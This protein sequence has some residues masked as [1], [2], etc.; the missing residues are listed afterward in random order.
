MLRCRWFVNC[1]VK[2]DVEYFGGFMKLSKVFV[3]WILFTLVSIA[4]YA[5]FY[6]EKPSYY[7][8]LDVG[9][10]SLSSANVT[11]D[12]NDRN[13]SSKDGFF[14]INNQIITHHIPI[15]DGVYKQVNISC[16]RL[17]DMAEGKCN[18]KNFKILNLS[19]QPVFSLDNELQLNRGSSLIIPLNSVKLAHISIVSYI[20]QIIN[21]V[22]LLSLTFCFALVFF[23]RRS[24]SGLIFSCALCIIYAYAMFEYSN[25]YTGTDAIENINVAT[26][27]FGK[28]PY[29][30][31]VEYRGYLWFVILWFISRISAVFS[32][33]FYYTYTIYGCILFALTVVVLLPKIITVISKKPSRSLNQIALLPLLLYLFGKQFFC[34]IPDTTPFVLLL[35][36]LYFMFLDISNKKNIIVAAVLLGSACL[37]RSNYYLSVISILLGILFYR[38]CNFKRKFVCCILFLCPVVILTATNKAFIERSNVPLNNTYLTQAILF[39]GMNVQKTS[40]FEIADV[41]G[42]TILKQSQIGNASEMN[43][44]KYFNL[45]LKYPVDFLTMYSIRLFNGLDIKYSQVY[46]YEAFSD[47]KGRVMFSLIN[48]IFLFYG[49]AY[50]FYWFNKDSVR[51]EIKFFALLSSLFLPSLSMVVSFVETRY[52]LPMSVFIL[53]YGCMSLNFDALKKGMLIKL[54]LFVIVCFTISAAVYNQS[55]HVLF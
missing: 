24:H 3:C 44:Q 41:R 53:S 32:L 13:I 22:I 43:P 17:G 37:I 49:F 2:C 34:P 36:S 23:N 55:V 42:S 9:A 7:I 54:V 33:S 14:S 19:G 48:Y 35:C 5:I 47:A 16:N 1:S 20:K 21:H 39:N 11:W 8:S 4:A 30:S 51:E 10:T 12:V 28:F 26:N 40:P 31:Y 46:A 18:I 50:L 27:F 6:T 29:T 45:I 52:F 25:V 38:S 15:S